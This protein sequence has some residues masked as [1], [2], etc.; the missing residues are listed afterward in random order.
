VRGILLLLPD[1]LALTP[2]Q[3]E[4]MQP[5]ADGLAGSLEN[6][7]AGR[8]DRRTPSLEKQLRGILTPEQNRFLAEHGEDPV[9]A[10][11]SEPGKSPLAREIRRFLAVHGQGYVPQ[12]ASGARTKP[13]AGTAPAATDAP[14][15]GP[16]IRVALLIMH[17]T[18]DLAL[19]RDQAV[20]LQP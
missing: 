3:V 5:L 6:L 12:F 10:L 16:T 1:E 17:G 7:Q 15:L 19:T 20:R 14:P 13:V 18:P 9:P 2:A 4:K 8:M 11:L